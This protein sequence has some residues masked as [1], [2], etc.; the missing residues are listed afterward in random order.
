MEHWWNTAHPASSG[1]G[2]AG[3]VLEVRL[4]SLGQL[5]VV[6]VFRKKKLET[7]AP[8]AILAKGGPN[9]ITIYLKKK[10]HAFTG[11][12]DGVEIVLDGFEPFL[13]AEY[14]GEV[15]LDR[16]QFLSDGGLFH[17][18]LSD[19]ISHTEELE[20]PEFDVGSKVIVIRDPDDGGSG[21]LIV[22]ARSGAEAYVAGRIPSELST[23]MGEMAPIG[24]V[25]EAVVI[26]TI[27]QDGVRS[28]LRLLGSVGRAV[29]LVRI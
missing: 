29:T 11:G 28:G 22:C 18:H 12:E 17:C 21:S 8:F 1:S 16:P 7:T 9:P 10:R 2:R 26:M 27:T 4:T 25:I 14:R 15:Y 20:R 13:S 24:G 3:F 19:G 6:P 5:E 23:L